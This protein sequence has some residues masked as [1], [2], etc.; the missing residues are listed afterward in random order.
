MERSRIILGQKVYN[1]L[2]PF[3]KEQWTPPLVAH[4]V[5]FYQVVYPIR[6]LTQPVYPQAVYPIRTLT[7]RPL[8]STP[9]LRTEWFE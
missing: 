9:L 7:S 3:S 1:E 4:P 6:S 8:L 2:N 5:S